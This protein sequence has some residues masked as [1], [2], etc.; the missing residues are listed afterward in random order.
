MEADRRMWSVTAR[1]LSDC[2]G[3]LLKA[4]YGSTSVRE[5]Q[6]KLKKHGVYPAKDLWDLCS[7]ELPDIFFTYDSSQNYVDIQQIVWQTLDFAAAALRKRRADVADEDLELLISDG[8]RIWV[9]FLFID[10]GSRDIPEELKVLPQLLR[11]VDA[12]FVL[13]STP[14]ERAWCCYEIALFNQKCATDE[15]LNLNSFI[16]PTK[17]YYNW[18]LVLS[19]EA[20]DKIYIEQQ[21][22]NTFPG[23]FE[24]FQNVMSQA[25][26]VALLSKTE[27]NVYYS[28]DSI[29]NLGIA[30]EKWFDRMQ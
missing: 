10:Q 29:E 5:L 20:E 1:G 21:I 9:D 8:V 28:P 3:E 4:G 16:A 30:A 14:L 17:P 19:T 13:G 2:V 11:N 18:D 12:H 24:G 7:A 26:S 15:R 6:L 25:S 22:R 23:G 27:G